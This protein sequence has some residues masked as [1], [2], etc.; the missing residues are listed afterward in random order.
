MLLG[1]CG[2]HAV[3][4]ALVATWLTV[5]GAVMQG[6]QQRHRD[7]KMCITRED[8]QRSGGASRVRGRRTRSELSVPA[9]F[10]ANCLLYKH[11]EPRA[12]HAT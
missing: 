1:R 5:R 10:P 4:A 8:R 2:Q 3:F 9:V 7:F 12:L 6:G 11:L